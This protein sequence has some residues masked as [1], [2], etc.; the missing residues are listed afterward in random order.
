MRTSL[1][2]PTIQE[3]LGVSSPEDNFL[4]VFFCVFYKSACID[5]D[6]S[7]YRIVSS[8]GGAHQLENK[9]KTPTS[10]HDGWTR[11]SPLRRK[12]PL[13]GNVEFY[14]YI[15]SR[16][17]L[18]QKHPMILMVDIN[19]RTEQNSFIL[20]RVPM[21]LHAATHLHIINYFWISCLGKVRGKKN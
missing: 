21:M 2:K 15:D 19:T 14:Q 3:R 20:T 11:L 5:G 9:E 16:L 13:H 6:G 8:E 12:S 10:Q 7:V 17:P 1:T 4:N 18:E